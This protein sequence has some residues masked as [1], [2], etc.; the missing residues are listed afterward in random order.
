MVVTPIFRSGG[1]Y[2]VSLGGFIKIGTS[3]D[4]VTRWRSSGDSP[5]PVQPLGFIPTDRGPALERELHAKFASLRYRGE[6]F[7][8][9]M[10]LLDY[11]STHAQPWPILL[12][13]PCQKSN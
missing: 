2:F 12:V 5:E 3:G 7:R 6:W 9:E 13:S 10:T 4:V 8:P 11:I 1:V